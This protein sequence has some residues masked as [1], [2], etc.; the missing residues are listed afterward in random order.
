[1]KMKMHPSHDPEFVAL[2]SYVMRRPEACA[3]LVPCDEDSRHIGEPHRTKSQAEVLELLDG[4]DHPWAVWVEESHSEYPPN[5]MMWLDDELEFGYFLDFI[6]DDENP[7]TLFYD[8][9]HG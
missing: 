8:E 1:M 7:I 2:V 4:S 5:F 3:V 6:P 9:Y